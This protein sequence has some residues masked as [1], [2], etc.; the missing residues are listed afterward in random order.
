[1]TKKLTKNNV[2]ELKYI[3]IYDDPDTYWATFDLG[4]SAALI[5]AGF[6]LASLEK[7]N[8]GKVHFIFLKSNNIE[9]VVADYWAD[10][11]EVKART[12]FDNTKMIKNR[13]Y[14]E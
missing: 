13:L 11:L 4:C 10:R 1:M 3:P 2:E 8:P 14:S 6:E 9:K 12:F 5:S 7:S